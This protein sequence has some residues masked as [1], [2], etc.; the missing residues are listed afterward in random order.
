MRK[1][2]P[3]FCG[4]LPFEPVD[5]RGKLPEGWEAASSASLQEGQIQILPGIGPWK[6]FDG[7]LSAFLSAGDKK[8]R[9]ILKV[10]EFYVRFNRPQW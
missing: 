3:G 9:F 1:M 8:D 6:E 5:I 2:L 4:N 7:F 10:Q